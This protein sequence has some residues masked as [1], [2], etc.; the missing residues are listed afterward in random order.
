MSRCASLPT[1]WPCSA[2]P[3]QRRHAAF[4]HKVVL[5]HAKACHL[6]AQ[7]R[8]ILAQ[9]RQEVSFELEEIEIDGDPELESRYREWLPVVEIDGD[10]AFV[11]YVD[12]DAFRRKV[13]AQS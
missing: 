9:V 8:E 10:R 6:C 7:A 1:A 13:A 12:P 3:K 5:Y 4:I 11:Y 2:S